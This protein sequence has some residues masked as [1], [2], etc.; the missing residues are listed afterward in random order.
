MRVANRFTNPANNA[1]YDWPL[2]HSSEETSGK[3]R[4]ITT[5]A[6]TG[7][8][9]LVRQQGDDGPYQLKWVGRILRRSQLAAMWEWYQL[10]RTQTIHLTDFDGQKYEGQITD[11]QPRRIRAE[12]PGSADPQTHVWEYTF[13]FDVYRFI[14]GDMFDEGVTP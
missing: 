10:C 4:N 1:I 9:G 2:N 12:R 11:F 13:T 6:P 3:A 7:G 8:V 14:D 5:T